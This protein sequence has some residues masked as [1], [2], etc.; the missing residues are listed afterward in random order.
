MWRGWGECIPCTMT[1]EITSTPAPTADQLAA[2]VVIAAGETVEGTLE[3]AD[4]VKYYRLEVAETSVVELTIDAEAGTEIAL[5][6]SSGGVV[7]VHAV[8]A[9]EGTVRHTVRQGSIYARVRN[10]V[11][12]VNQSKIFRLV[13]KVTKVTAYAGAVINAV[14]GIPK[15]EIPLGPGGSAGIK[16]D[17]TGVF[18]G[19]D[20]QPLTFKIGGHL[21]FL[22]VEFEKESFRL[23]PTSD[24]VPGPLNLTI[25]ATP[26]DVD[27]IPGA[28]VS[29]TMTLV[30]APNRAPRPKPEYVDGDVLKFLT[31][32][33]WFSAQV[34]EYMEDDQGDTLRWEKM[35]TLSSIGT[36]WSAQLFG[37]GTHADT[38]KHT[39]HVELDADQAMAGDN[40][41]L[42]LTA[43]DEENLTG[44]LVFVIGAK[45]KEP[46]GD[47]SA[48]AACENALRLYAAWSAAGDEFVGLG[49]I[50]TP[51]PTVEQIR[52]G[53]R[54][55][56]DPDHDSTYGWCPTTAVRHQ[57][58]YDAADDR[59]R[60]AKREYSAAY[61]V[62]AGG[63][64]T[65][66]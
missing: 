43:I 51:K 27:N 58:A 5:L 17:F 16:Y 50:G 13:N 42:K 64:Y 12:K 40:I 19:P 4:D 60:A 47:A 22:S 11:K 52:S 30:E 61:E 6:D 9:S 24:A 14:R 46:A 35:E 31:P 45:V 38:N 57:Q 10:A 26:L 53:D 49:C 63:E 55:L 37:T 48:S 2:A 41:R 33:Q 62:L 20:D 54:E 66:Q 15:G 3:S 32:G 39:L 21:G 23:T 29:F 36:G 44:T 18:S 1:P 34:L 65:C 7:L 28:S 8:T 25:T 56:P 59:Y